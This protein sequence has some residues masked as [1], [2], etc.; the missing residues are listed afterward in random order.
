M[1]LFIKGKDNPVFVKPGT[2]GLLRF[3]LIELD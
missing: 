2:C 1:F 3:W